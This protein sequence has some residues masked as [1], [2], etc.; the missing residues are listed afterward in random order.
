V[1]SR[2]VRE[3]LA[4]ATAEVSV[5]E[6]GRR[7]MRVHVKLPASAQAS[8]AEVERALSPYLFEAEVTTG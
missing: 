7:G 3:E 5:I 2:I 8:I 6:G 1:V 4:L